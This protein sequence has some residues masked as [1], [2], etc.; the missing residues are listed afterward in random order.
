MGWINS[1]AAALTVF[2]LS[3]VSRP[4]FTLYFILKVPA[5]QYKADDSRLFARICWILQVHA[6]LSIPINP[7]FKTV[8]CD[9]TWASE[10]FSMTICLHAPR[11]F[12]NTIL[13]TSKLGFLDYLLC[14]R[15]NLV[16][17]FFLIMKDLQLFV[18][19]N[20]RCTMAIEWSWSFQFV[21]LQ[22]ELLNLACCKEIIRNKYQ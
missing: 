1:I 4:A 11:Y 17:L 16:I 15:L 14:V 21:L 12:N 3:I 6:A 18:L 5:Y 10:I 2:N 7:S 20:L 22:Q 8:I 19:P 9:W 13:L